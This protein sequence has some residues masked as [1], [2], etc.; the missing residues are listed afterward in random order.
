MS[1]D[2]TTA[3]RA[4]G[5]G[6][7]AEREVLLED[8]RSADDSDRGWGEERDSGGPAEADERFLRELPPHWS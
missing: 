7:D 8:E 6:E 4:R 5:E 3:G 1:A 2:G